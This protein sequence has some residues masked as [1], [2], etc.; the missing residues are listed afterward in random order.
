MRSARVIL[1]LLLLALSGAAA[2]RAGDEDCYPIA[3]TW[4][5]PTG[6]AGCT[7]D[8]PTSG[9]ASWYSGDMAA[10]NWCTWPFEDCGWVT[11]QSHAT[12]LTIT[13]EVGMYGD[14]YTNTP[15]ERLI[16]LTRGQVLALGLDPAS[17]LF[18]VTVAS[19]SG[20]SAGPASLPSGT[21]L[22]HTAIGGKKC[23]PSST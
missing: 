23:S 22:A 8:G 12:G 17:G 21:V 13:V 6:V 18:A 3:V 9:I 14:L 2:V 20:S 7:L 5:S 1:A 11:V 10:A 16:D 19:A 15:D 4:Y